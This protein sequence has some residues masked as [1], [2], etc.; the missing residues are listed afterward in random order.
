MLLLGGVVAVWGAYDAVRHDTAYAVDEPGS[1]I[2]GD[3]LGGAGAMVDSV[4]SGPPAPVSGRATVDHSRARTGATREP[5]PVTAGRAVT[6]E[7]ASES[8]PAV[9]VP[10]ADLSAAVAPV[11]R[12]VGRST[13]AGSAGAVEVVAPVTRPVVA[14]AAPVVQAVAGTG[15]LEP[16]DAVLRPVTE[17]IVRTLHPVLAPVLGLTG[18]ILGQPAVPPGDPADP[19]PQPAGAVPTTTPGDTGHAIRMPAVIPTDPAAAPAIPSRDV[20]VPCRSGGERAAGA[21]DVGRGPG[22]AEGRGTGGLTTLS[23]GSATGSAAAAA[24]TPTAADTS[25]HPWTPELASRRCASSRCDMSAQRSPQP[26][27]RPA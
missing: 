25:P 11:R 16:V 6:R 15:I 24:G 9:R 21:A 2:V 7:P 17:P 10:P 20:T 23:S 14:A 4:L 22:R 1:G 3:L 8:D 27:T 5:G 26:G 18:P 19:R 12:L 13:G